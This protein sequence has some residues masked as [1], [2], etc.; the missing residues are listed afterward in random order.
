LKVY[1]IFGI[2]PELCGFRILIIIE[3][4]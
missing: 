1:T 4:F 3:A 2:V